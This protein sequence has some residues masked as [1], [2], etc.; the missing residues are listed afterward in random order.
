MSEKSGNEIR[1]RPAPDPRH[2]HPDASPD[3][4]ATLD[5]PD[6]VPL[7]IHTRT[8]H[9]DTDR[10]LILEETHLPGHRVRIVGRT[11]R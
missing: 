1:T 8:T 6:G 3:I 11:K 4:A 5:I 7:L 9:D 10:P 2:H